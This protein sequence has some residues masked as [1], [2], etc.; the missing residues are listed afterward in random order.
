MLSKSFSLGSL[1]S[2]GMHTGLNYNTFEDTDDRNL[3]AFAGLDK[4]LN[5]QIFVI[6][7]YNLALDDNS[8]LSLGKERGYLNAGL[9][10]IFAQQLGIEFNFKDLLENQK[11]LSSISRELRITYVET[12]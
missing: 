8:S 1:G 11:D 3:N 7:E 2:L 9:R 6:A 10:W 5:Q 12:F 4:N